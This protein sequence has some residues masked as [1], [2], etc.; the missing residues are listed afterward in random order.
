MLRPLQIHS[1]KGPLPVFYL[2]I[3]L[4]V[5]PIKTAGIRKDHAGESVPAS[6]LRCIVH[7]KVNKWIPFYFALGP[8]PI[9]SSFTTASVLD[10]KAEPVHSEQAEIPSAQPRAPAWDISSQRANGTMTL[11]RTDSLGDC[12]GGTALQLWHLR[13]KSTTLALGTPRRHFLE[14]IDRAASAF[15]TEIGGNTGHTFA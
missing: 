1:G 8:R 2:S 6:T 9:A 13:L 14:T 12:G 15:G 3:C 11:R 4:L 7:N 10:E 5:H